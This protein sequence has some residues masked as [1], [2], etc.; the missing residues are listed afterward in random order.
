[1]QL[2]SSTDRTHAIVVSTLMEACEVVKEGLVAD[3]TVNDVCPVPKLFTQEMIDC[4]SA[5][6][7]RLATP[8]EQDSRPLGSVG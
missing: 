5:D 3:G 4:S 6:P 2:I 8:A 7:L 1:M